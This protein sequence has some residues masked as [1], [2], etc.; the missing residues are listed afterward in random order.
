MRQGL[1]RQIVIDKRRLRANSPQRKPHKHKGIRV[2]KVHGHDILGLDAKL[3]LDP[4]AVAEDSVVRLRIRVRPAV[5]D[6]ER[7][8]GVAG[9][10]GMALQGVEEVD[11]VRPKTAADADGGLDNTLYER[12]VVPEAG[13]GVEVGQGGGCGGEDDG[14]GDWHGDVSCGFVSM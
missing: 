5:K 8:V 7:L 14:E 11:C 10:L 1:P 6:E 3:G 4:V 13:F 2:F 12:V 9:A